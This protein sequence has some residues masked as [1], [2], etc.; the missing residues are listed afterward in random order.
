MATSIISL[1]EV[2]TANGSYSVEIEGIDKKAA[3]KEFKKQF[4]QAGKPSSIE[5]IAQQS[6]KPE[7]PN[8][9]GNGKTATTPQKPEVVVINPTEPVKVAHPVSR[10]NLPPSAVTVIEE[11]EFVDYLPSKI[12]AMTMIVIEGKRI[13]HNEDVTTCAVGFV[14]LR[15]GGKRYKFGELK[16]GSLVL[17]D[18]ALDLPLLT[19]GVITNEDVKALQM[20]VEK[21]WCKGTKEKLA[22]EKKLSKS[23]KDAARKAKM[24]AITDLM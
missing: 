17:D 18:E 6:E 2:K 8:G 1:W 13:D 21:Q 19:N 20:E 15:I 23:A 24:K 10:E 4:P 7:A 14:H 11:Y 12:I 5:M 16:R 22:R 9:N 3:L